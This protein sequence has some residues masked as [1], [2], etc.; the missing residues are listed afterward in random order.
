M[1]APS[2][3]QAELLSRAWFG[4]SVTI[5]D[6]GGWRPP[7]AVACLKRGWLLRVPGPPGEYPNGSTFSRYVASPDGLRALAAFLDKAAGLRSPTPSDGGG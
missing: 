6:E 3:S 5:A 4:R 7:T 2:P 1:G